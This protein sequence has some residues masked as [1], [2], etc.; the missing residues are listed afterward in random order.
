MTGTLR[1]PVLQ[2]DLQSTIMRPSTWAVVLCGPCVASTAPVAR[3]LV[4]KLRRVNMDKRRQ[5]NGTP[6]KIDAIWS[7][8]ARRLRQPISREA[9]V[10]LCLWTAFRQDRKSL[11]SAWGTVIGLRLSGAGAERYDGQPNDKSELLAAARRSHPVRHGLPRGP[12]GG[13]RYQC[14]PSF[15]PSAAAVMIARIPIAIVASAIARASI[16]PFPSKSAS[17]QNV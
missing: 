6:D 15:E 5:P 14:S 13:P 9:R 3:V 8:I 4:T 2:M 10:A 12:S 16:M 7:Q 17:C 1:T 11:P